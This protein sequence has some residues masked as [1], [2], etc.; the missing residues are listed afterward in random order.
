V[1]NQNEQSTRREK[2]T[3][4]KL[5]EKEEEELFLVSFSSLYVVNKKQC[6]YIVERRQ[7][8]IKNF[9]MYERH[10]RVRGKIQN[11]RPM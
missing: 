4:S 10:E 2:K 11:G 1:K 8:H 7:K 9:L 3:S 5:N 6:V